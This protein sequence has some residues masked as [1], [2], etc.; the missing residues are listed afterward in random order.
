MTHLFNLQMFADEGA[1]ETTTE[2]T[3]T[4][5]EETAAQQEEKSPQKYTDEDVDRIVR[6]KLAAERKKAE[7]ERKER[8]EAKKLQEMNN[9]QKAEYEL[10]QLKEEL[11][12]LKQKDAQSEMLKTARGILADKNITVGDELVSMLISTDADETN[13]AV[14]QFADLFKSEVDKAVKEALKGETPRK[15]APAG[16]MTKEQ[17]MDVKNTAERQKLIKEHMDLFK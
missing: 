6:Q 16:G 14:N 15:G 7:K 8:D 11:A 3:E 4:T 1:D 10:Q 5:E 2:E 13:D 17:I 12:S 9:Q